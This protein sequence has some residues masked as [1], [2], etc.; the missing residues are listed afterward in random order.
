MSLAMSCK[1][2]VIADI[3]LSACLGMGVTPIDILFVACIVGFTLVTYS[4]VI[5]GVFFRVVGFSHDRAIGI[6]V[7]NTGRMN[8]GVTGSLHIGLH[9]RCH[10]HN[11][12]TSRP[13]LVS[14]VVVKIG[15]CPGSSALVRELSSHSI[16]AVVVSPTG[17]SRLGG[18]SVTSHL[19]TR[20][21]GLLATPPLD[22]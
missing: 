7:C 14:G 17:V 6:F 13:R 19:L 3:L 9:G 2:L 15:I 1:I 12:V 16:D 8:M 5:I 20:G 22:R 10:L 11:F 4:H 18:A 21:V